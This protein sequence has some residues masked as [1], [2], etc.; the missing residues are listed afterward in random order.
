MGAERLSDIVP[1]KMWEDRLPH[2]PF[3]IKIFQT[4]TLLLRE[5]AGLEAFGFYRCL[6]VRLGRGY[7]RRK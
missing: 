5:Y 2:F 3:L 4:E 7:T 1:F 6:F